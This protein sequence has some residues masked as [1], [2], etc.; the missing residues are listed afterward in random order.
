MKLLPL[1]APVALFASVLAGPYAMAAPVAYQLAGGGVGW[2]TDLTANINY[3]PAGGGG[4][5]EDAWVGPLSLNVTNLGN[6]TTDT[7]VVY[8]T[9]IFDDY[10]S[11]GIYQL[12][13][14]TQTVSLTTADRIDALL[15]HVTPTT[16]IEGAALQASIWKVENDPG[17]YNIQNGIFSITPDGI[18]GNGAEYQAF[19][20]QA[21][22]YLANIESGAWQSQPGTTVLQY[23]ADP[24]GGPNQSFAFLE[25][26]M[27][28]TPEPASLAVLGSGV[29]ALIGLRRRRQHRIS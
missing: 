15:S 19:I 16:A 10:R 3:S 9:D 29:V 6:N 26:A 1:L 28:S 5:S 22:V 2:S 7:Q 21:D 24:A 27:H 23:T 25:P 14:L 12:G 8:C 18:T 4:F 11:G 17:N 20:T 13:L